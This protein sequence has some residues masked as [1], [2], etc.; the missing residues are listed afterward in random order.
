M[1]SHQIVALDPVHTDWKAILE[2]ILSAF[3]YM[4]GVIDPPSSAYRLTVDNLARKAGA[5]RG[6]AIYADGK[7]VACMFCDPRPDCLYVGKLAIDPQWQ[8]K[9]L[10]RKLVAHARTLARELGYDEIELQTR[11]ELTGNHRFFEGLG[12]VKTGEDAHEGYDRPT[13]IRMRMKV[14]G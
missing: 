13:S 7:P 9:G 4:D 10:G 1:N 12:F 11:V 8:G 2:L 6:F 3:A 14:T 5:E